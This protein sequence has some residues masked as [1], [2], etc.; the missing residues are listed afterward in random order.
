MPENLSHISMNEKSMRL[1]ELSSS[2]D[3][4]FLNYIDQFQNQIQKMNYGEEENN[5]EN[6]QNDREEE[7]PPTE[8]Q[9]LQVEEEDEKEEEEENRKEQIAF[10]N[11]L[12]LENTLF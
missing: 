11:P 2:E 1:K 3:E 5:E 8:S 4:D 9:A 6:N 10:L 7:S 12:P